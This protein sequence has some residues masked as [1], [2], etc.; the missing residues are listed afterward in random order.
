[1]QIMWHAI[2]VCAQGSVSHFSNLNMLTLVS[3]LVL[4]KLCVITKYLHDNCSMVVKPCTFL[5]YTVLLNCIM[6]R[7]NTILF[8]SLVNSVAMNYV[9][10]TNS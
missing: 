3:C 4:D 2:S 5:Y 10:K 6:S 7:F 8:E 1:M 9:N